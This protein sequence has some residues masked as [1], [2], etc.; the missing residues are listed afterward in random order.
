V[1]NISGSKTP[2][3]EGRGVLSKVLF[4]IILN[5]VVLFALGLYAMNVWS[6]SAQTLEQSRQKLSLVEQAR[7]NDSGLYQYVYSG[8]HTDIDE[9]DSGR[10]HI[11]SV[12]KD[13]PELADD[14]DV[15]RFLSAENDWNAKFARPLIQKRHNMDLAK[16]NIT[17]NDMVM[18]YLNLRVEGLQEKLHASVGRLAT[19]ANQKAASASSELTNSLD[20]A[21]YALIILAIMNLFAGGALWFTFKNELAAAA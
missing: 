18:F 21:K 9:F 10:D 20:F 2:G 16:E 11:S 8:V 13:T 7:K 12:V 19:N 4:Q 15:K 17:Q 14:S 1:E 3:S 5:V 6:E